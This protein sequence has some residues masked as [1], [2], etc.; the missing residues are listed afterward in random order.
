MPLLNNPQAEWPHPAL[1]TF[2]QN[3]HTLRTEKWRYIRY[4]NGDEELYDHDKDPN[5]WTNLAKNP[6]Y[7]N[8]IA[9]LKKKLPKMNAQDSPA[10]SKKK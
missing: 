8:I 7:Q 9:R 3:D 6:N 1:T 4:A 5:E 10:L 2:H